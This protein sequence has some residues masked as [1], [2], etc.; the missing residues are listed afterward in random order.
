MKSNI[1]KR[2]HIKAGKQV[3]KIKLEMRNKLIIAIPKA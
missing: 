1:I 3:K 2:T